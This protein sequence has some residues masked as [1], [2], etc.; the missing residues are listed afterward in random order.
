MMENG[1]DNMSSIPQPP[2]FMPRDTELFF[3]KLEM[4]FDQHKIKN[5]SKKL[6]SLV[7]MINDESLSG[8]IKNVLTSV[9]QLTHPYRTL[10][11]KI[12]TH[13]T[14]SKDVKL[15]MFLKT[16]SIGDMKPSQFLDYLYSLYDP[17]D[18]N[19]LIVKTKF[20]NALSVD[21]QS[22]LATMPDASLPELAVTADRIFSTRNQTPPLSI[23]KIS[24]DSTLVQEIS[25]LFQKELKIVHQTLAEQK[26]EI[27]NLKLQMN[28]YDKNNQFSKEP[29]LC[30]YHKKF[31]SNAKKCDST[32][33]KYEGKTD[34][35]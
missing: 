6:L 4:Y 32:C 19:S 17:K 23:N 16:S 1:T 31:G 33:S 9:D 21:I 24:N 14:L 7:S 18:D 5:E 30:Y 8:I 34:L 25:S 2:A 28:R 22:I 15:D 20:L 27:R 26:E 3:L 13:T 29:S 11:E 35:N 10:K 12:L